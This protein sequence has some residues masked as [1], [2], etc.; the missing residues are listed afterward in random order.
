[1]IVYHFC[2]DLNHFGVI[3]A[4]FNRHGGWLAFRTVIVSL[5]VTLVGISLVLAERH[6]RKRSF[7]Q[8]M[9]MLLAGC[10]LVSASSYLMFPRSWIFFGIL[11][12][13]LIASLA[14]T[15]FLRL[16]PRALLLTGFALLV[17]GTWVTHPLFD[18][19]ALQWIGM[20]TFKPRT[21]DYVP[22][23]PWF[24][25]I[26]IGMAIGSGLPM[27][28]Q[29][30]LHWQTGNASFALLARAGRHS[31][32]IYLVHQPLL[33]GLLYILKASGFFGLH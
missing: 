17:C 23:L 10:L 7:R 5:F 12:F 4:D 2:F 22:L 14:A 8:R 25:L 1:M 27:Q 32:L 13:I 33:I 20:M 26:L 6:G 9:L 24:G 16:S 15:G 18:Q 29:A 28:A 19:P 31:L 21:E 3:H 11:H 30:A